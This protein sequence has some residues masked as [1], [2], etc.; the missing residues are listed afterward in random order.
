VKGDV[1]HL[2]NDQ[3]IPAS[4]GVNAQLLEKVEPFPTEQLI[5]YNPSYV[6]GWT[7][8][9]YQL[10][11]EN[12]AEKSSAKMN[13]FLREMIVRQIPGNTYQNLSFYPR[14]S[15]QTFK[16]ILAPVWIVTYTY[17]QKTFQVLVNG[18]TG[19]IA[20]NYPK[21]WIKIALA[22]IGVL[23]AALAL[24]FVRT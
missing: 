6:T 2:F 17:G 8:E 20:G 4:F 18:N 24:D 12:A 19:T 10:D 13:A 5:P 21:S 23:A 7:V 3:L 16:H 11:L 9:Q 14:Y 15:S 1:S 22:V